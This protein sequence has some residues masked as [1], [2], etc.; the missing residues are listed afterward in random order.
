M[1]RHNIE[2]REAAHCVARR[3]ADRRDAHGAG[4]GAGGAPPAL[5]NA[6]VQRHVHARLARPPCHRSAGAFRTQ[7]PCLALDQLYFE[8]LPRRV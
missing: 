2:A 7:T 1:G 8:P 4:T 3:D 6:L 5:A